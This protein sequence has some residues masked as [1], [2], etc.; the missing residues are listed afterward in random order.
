MLAALDAF[1]LSFGL[2]SAEESAL[3]RACLVEDESARRDRTNADL[4]AALTAAD[5]GRRWMLPLLAE[6]LDRDGRLDGA[7]GIRLRAAALHETGRSATFDRITAQVLAVLGEAGCAPMLSRGQ[8]LAL[9]AYPRSALR[10]RHDLDA[11]VGGAGVAAGAAALV[12]AGLGRTETGVQGGT[13]LAHPSG[14]RI[15]LHARPLP[16]PASSFG[17]AQLRDGAMVERIDGVSFAVPEPAALLLH[18]LLLPACTAGTRLAWAADAAMAITR[19]PI[20]W[21]RVAAIGGADACDVLARLDY[22]AE[23]L[24]VAVPGAVRAR[25]RTT[26]AG[27]DPAAREVALARARRRRG[28]RAMLRHARGFGAT[29]GLLRW[30]IAPVRRTPA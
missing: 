14:L 23:T 8:A 4:L 25:L 3:L 1:L 7:E 6:R 24:G 30:L 26:I 17:M 19:T 10:H 2:P 11:L 29:A 12:Q 13:L 28:A 27:L 15:H 16:G 9:S 5:A 22:L 18:V 20:A 21:E